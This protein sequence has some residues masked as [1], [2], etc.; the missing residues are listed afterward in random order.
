MGFLAFPLLAARVERDW[1][2]LRNSKDLAC[3]TSGYLKGVMEAGFRFES[4]CLKTVATG[5][6][7]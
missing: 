1:W 3:W 2:Q 7:L 6:R 4:G 5:V